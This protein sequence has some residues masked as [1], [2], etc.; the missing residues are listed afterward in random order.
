[1]YKNSELS[2]PPLIAKKEL[3]LFW[4]M[5]YVMQ[6]LN[7]KFIF[8]QHFAKLKKV[9]EAFEQ[10]LLDQNK[11][12]LDHIYYYGIND[13]FNTKNL[14][15]SLLEIFLSNFLTVLTDVLPLDMTGAVLDIFLYTGEKVVMDI[16]LRAIHFNKEHI[17]LT[18][19]KEKLRN[20]LKRDM[21]IGFFESRQGRLSEVFPHSLTQKIVQ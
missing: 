21:I 10:R 20:F 2:F 16:I 8:M 9:A 7:W 15:F 13:G 5:V 19:E 11:E 17:L 12:V 14:D 6:E 3:F 1:M 4:I 18:K